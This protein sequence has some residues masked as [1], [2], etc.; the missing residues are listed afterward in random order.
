MSYSILCIRSLRIRAEHAKNRIS[1]A[2]TADLTA[3]TSDNPCD[4]K[5]EYFWET[6][7]ADD[8]KSALTDFPV[9][10]ID[11]SCLN[12]DENFVFLG[13][14]NFDFRMHLQNVG[15]SI[16]INECCFHGHSSITFAS[17]ADLCYV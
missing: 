6:K 10:G 7:T 1:D 17:F 8:F 9:D 3:Y 13:L 15:G 5:S 4:V 12:S 14:R 16:G 11:G 2:K